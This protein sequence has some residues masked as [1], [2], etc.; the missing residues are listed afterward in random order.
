MSY[1]NPFVTEGGDSC[2]P[3]HHGFYE[4]GF[5]V[6]SRWGALYNNTGFA[7]HWEHFDEATGVTTIVTEF[8]VNGDLEMRVRKFNADQHSFHFPRIDLDPSNWE[9]DPEWLREAN[10]ESEGT[11]DLAVEI[12]VAHVDFIIE[13]GA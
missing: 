6:T 13:E 4:T 2:T 9:D 10:K 1:F 5:D 11:A 3:E 7:V 12:P 8:D